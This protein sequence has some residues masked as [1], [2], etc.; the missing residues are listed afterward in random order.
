MTRRE[1]E[2]IVLRYL[3]RQWLPYDVKIDYDHLCA[4]AESQPRRYALVEGMGLL[5]HANGSFYRI[6][7][8]EG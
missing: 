2:S 1:A 4:I 7:D 8:V 6:E 5:E 3:S